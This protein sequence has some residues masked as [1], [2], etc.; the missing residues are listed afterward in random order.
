MLV[1]SGRD[2]F[3]GL[4]EYE[5]HSGGQRR[6]NGNFEIGR[7]ALGGHRKY[8]HAPLGQFVPYRLHKEIE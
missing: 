2:E 3:P 8:K 1:E 7:E 5:R 4:I 6:I